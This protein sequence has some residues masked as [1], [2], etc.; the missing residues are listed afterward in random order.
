MTPQRLPSRSSRAAIIATTIVTVL[1]ACAAD[2]TAPRT[3]A[4]RAALSRAAAPRASHAEAT[5]RDVSGADI[6]TAR[7]TQDATGR[8]HLTVHVKGIA[9]GRHG[10]HLHA[11]GA[12]DAGTPTPFS[13]AGSHYNPTRR[14]HGH[15]NPLGHHAGDLP[16]LVVNAAGVGRLSE[17]LEQFTLSA[18]A[19]ADGT[20][21]VLHQ[22]E[23]DRRTDTGP[24]G[25]GN[26]GARIA[27]GVVA[28][29]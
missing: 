27:C 10:L 24:S 16:N 20:A 6:G 9:P 25:P 12:C 18:L 14:Q 28:G 13:S 22:N 19:D 7:F 3:S 23:D 1:A 17:T 26:S 11:I 4:D 15:D 29:R 5:L 8:V 21:L 2:A